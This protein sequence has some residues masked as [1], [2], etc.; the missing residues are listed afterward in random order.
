MNRKQSSENL[1]GLRASSLVTS[2]GS[3]PPGW[4]KVLDPDSGKFY[5][6]NR[7]KNLTQWENPNGEGGLPQVG[8]VRLMKVQEIL[9]TLILRQVRPN[10]MNLDNECLG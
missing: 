3:L 4:E 7:L 9:I 6:L 8:K 1:G 10:G 2:R 5:Y